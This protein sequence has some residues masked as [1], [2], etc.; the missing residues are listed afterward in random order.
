MCMDNILL[1]VHLSTNTW[2]ASSVLAIIAQALLHV[3]VQE[4]LNDL[5]TEVGL[6]GC[7]VIL[8]DF[9]RNCH[10]VFHASDLAFSCWL[11]L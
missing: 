3:V 7:V 1:T 6:L 10:A 9:L 11:P 8:L 5:H 2:V 4:S